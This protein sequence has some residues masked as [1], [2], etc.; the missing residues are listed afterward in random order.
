MAEKD[1]KDSALDKDATW[2]VI[3]SILSLFSIWIGYYLTTIGI[4]RNLGWAIFMSGLLVW[5]VVFWK[6]ACVGAY[7]NWW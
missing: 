6:L 7:N 1:K 4:S 3:I 5:L 2:V